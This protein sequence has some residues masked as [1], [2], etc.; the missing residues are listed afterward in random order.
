MTIQTRPNVPANVLNS[1][2]AAKQQRTGNGKKPANGKQASPDIATVLSA[3]MQ[4]LDRL[5][6]QPPTDDADDT[7]DA[8]IIG[9]EGLPFDPHNPLN[10]T[11]PAF[12]EDQDER[13]DERQLSS[14]NRQHD[15]HVTYQHDT[16]NDIARP[17]KGKATSKG[18]TIAWIGAK[19]LPKGA[20]PTLCHAPSVD[21]LI[22]KVMVEEEQ[23]DSSFKPRKNEEV[24]RNADDGKLYVW[25]QKSC[26]LSALTAA[27]TYP[28]L[29]AQHET[30]PYQLAI[31]R[32]GKLVA[33]V[34]NLEPT[35]S[36][37]GSVML[38]CPDAKF[39][40]SIA[41]K[42]GKGRLSFAGAFY[43]V[44]SLFVAERK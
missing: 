7:D 24:R 17:R 37:G 1:A 11:D 20:E 14:I 9:Q 13:Q 12:T 21:D 33:T 32:D 18:G 4:R 29:E 25:R 35:V 38:A 34:G 23:V 43:P 28:A 44:A 8:D 30:S 19:P 6:A 39:D 36:K 16:G 42:T 22:R 5:E 3:I 40:V 41:D 10:P 26:R 31:V 2:N 15:G 27:A